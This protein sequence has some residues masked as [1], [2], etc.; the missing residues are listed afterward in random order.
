MGAVGVEAFQRAQ[1][2]L[3]VSDMADRMEKWDREVAAM[4]R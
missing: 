2:T 3:L 4:P 1:A